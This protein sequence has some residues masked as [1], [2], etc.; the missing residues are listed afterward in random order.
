MAPSASRSHTPTSAV[1][2][3]PRSGAALHQP[4]A[5]GADDPDVLYPGR[6]G[7][8]IPVCKPTEVLLGAIGANCPPDVTVATGADVTG[9]GSGDV[10]ARRP[11]PRTVLPPQP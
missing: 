10:N 4:A 2:C 8:R 11:F 6:R 5:E 9:G 7:R 3:R 1:R